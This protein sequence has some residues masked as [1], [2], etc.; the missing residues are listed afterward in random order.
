MLKEFNISISN[1]GYYT[2]YVVYLNWKTLKK[3]ILNK[4]VAFSVKLSEGR[5][6]LRCGV[7]PLE[8]RISSLQ[9]IDRT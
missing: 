7:S 5:H 1:R 8:G 9:C 4:S 6:Q 2:L 3:K